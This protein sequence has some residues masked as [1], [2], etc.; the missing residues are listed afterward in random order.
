MWLQ[1]AGRAGQSPHVQARAI[2]LVESSALQCVGS[3]TVEENNEEEEVCVAYCKK[4]EPAL[5][6]WVE[7][8]DCRREIADKFFDNPPGRLRESTTIFPHH[9]LA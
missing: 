1:H 5:R 9:P 4:V 2:L 7:M 8:E 3:S 6:E